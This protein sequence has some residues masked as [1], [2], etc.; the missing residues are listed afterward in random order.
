MC[1]VV[2]QRLNSLVGSPF[3]TVRYTPPHPPPRDWSVY[4][5][6]NPPVMTIIVFLHIDIETRLQNTG[7]LTLWDHL[8]LD[9]T[10]FN[11]FHSYWKVYTIQNYSACKDTLIIRPVYLNSK[12][13]G[14]LEWVSGFGSSYKLCIQNTA[15]VLMCAW[16]GSQVFS[17]RVLLHTRVATSTPFLPKNLTIDRFF[18]ADGERKPSN[19]EHI[20]GSA[21]LML[22][23][24]LLWERV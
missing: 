8:D 18:L 13:K 23:W 21:L 11:A 16:V 24:C 4:L 2:S 3:N 17:K 15:Q 14:G 20:D 19:I 6:S 5:Q 9:V 22:S 10:L 1:H 12:A 7:L